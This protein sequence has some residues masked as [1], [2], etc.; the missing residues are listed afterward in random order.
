LRART[1]QF[2]EVRAAGE[3]DVVSDRAAV[4]PESD[5]PTVED[6]RAI[7]VLIQRHGVLFLR[8]S[9]GPAS[10]AKEGHSR[11]YESGLELPGLSV[12]V[13]SPEPWWTRPVE[14]WVARRICKYDELDDEER[15]PWLLTG[16]PVGFGP[17]HEPLL[18]KARPVA[19]VGTGALH[20][21]RRIYEER[22]DVGQDASS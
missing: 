11:D 6:L 20:E 19:R 16:Q 14:E 8:Y 1:R 22:F 21:A 7:V 18:Q 13:V 2:P 3:E 10:D 17:D 12:T 15:Y 9:K 5:L 4:D